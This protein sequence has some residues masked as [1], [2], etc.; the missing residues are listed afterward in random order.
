LRSAMRASC[1]ASGPKG[2]GP[3]GRAGPRAASGRPV[4]RLFLDA[5]DLVTAAAIGADGLERRADRRLVRRKVG[6]GGLGIRAELG[7]MRLEVVHGFP[8]LRARLGLMAGLR[9]GGELVG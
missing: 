9:A 5:V 2:A 4:H 8:D 7:G 3:A 1:D 6:K